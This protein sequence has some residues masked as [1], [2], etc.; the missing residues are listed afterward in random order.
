MRRC[1]TTITV[2]SANL[3]RST[4]AATNNERA[5]AKS[6]A[7]KGGTDTPRADGLLDDAVRGQ[8]NVR[9]RLIHDLAG[10]EYECDHM[11]Q[12]AH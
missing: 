5:W 12:S 11:N 6:K 8:I 7:R 3:H 9:G 2:Q 1:A 4:A 10:S